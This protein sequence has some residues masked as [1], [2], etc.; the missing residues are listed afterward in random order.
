MITQEVTFQIKVSNPID[1]KERIRKLQDLAKLSDADLALIHEIA[2]SEKYLMLL[3]K[4]KTKLK[5]LALTQ[6]M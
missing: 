1:T 2:R 4:N 5:M 6:I 3:K